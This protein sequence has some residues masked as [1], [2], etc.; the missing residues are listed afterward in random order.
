MSNWVGSVRFTGAIGLIIPKIKNEFL[1]KNSKKI[2]TL[3]LPGQ[4][5]NSE[6]QFWQP[7]SSMN[8]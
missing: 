5:A 8:T 6:S 3:F 2:E 4:E 7:I 1:M